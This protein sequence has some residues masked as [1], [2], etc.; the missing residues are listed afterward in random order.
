VRFGT[1]LPYDTATADQNARMREVNAWIAGAGVDFVDTRA[2]V[3]H[4]ADRDRLASSPDG[5]HPS[6]DGYRQMA[7]AIRPALER[8]VAIIDGCSPPGSERAR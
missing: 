3:A 8:I 4:P 1:I 7:E 5:L 2:A 6:P